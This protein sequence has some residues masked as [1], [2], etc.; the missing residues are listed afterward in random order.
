MCMCMCMCTCNMR[1]HMH[2]LMLHMHMHMCMPHV[3]AW[4]LY[5][6]TRAHTLL[7]D[8]S[9]TAA[10][11]IAACPCYLVITPLYLLGAMRHSRAA[12][13]EHSPGRR[14]AL[15]GARQVSHRGIEPSVLTTRYSLLA[16]HY[17][18]LTTRYSL[19]NA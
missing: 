8:A 19:L 6:Y 5:Y 11:T 15:R 7:T 2:M 17:S 14:A 12:R 10:G 18:L 4:G 9:H 1:M 16:T 3:P 13:Q